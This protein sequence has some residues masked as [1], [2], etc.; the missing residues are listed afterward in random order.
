MLDYT[1]EHHKGSLVQPL[2]L[3]CAVS[4]RSQ[5][6]QAGFSQEAASKSLP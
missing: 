6:K 4:S 1:Q 5:M 2:P 3:T